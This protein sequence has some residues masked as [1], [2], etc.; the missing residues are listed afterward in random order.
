MTS[1]EIFGSVISSSGRMDLIVGAARAF[2]INY[3]DKLKEFTKFMS[4]IRK[5]SGL[6]ND[7][8]H[9]LTVGTKTGY[10]LQPAL[11]ASRKFE[12]AT[13]RMDNGSFLYSDVE[14]VDIEK[15]FRDVS[16]SIFEKIGEIRDWMKTIHPENIPPYCGRTKVLFHS[17]KK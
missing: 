1:R 10:Y 11:Y 12:G 3:P 6:R 13:L 9:G 8:A 7:L 4:D 2:Y 15:R 14:I 17:E 5:M 16:D